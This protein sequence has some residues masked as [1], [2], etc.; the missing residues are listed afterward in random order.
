[1]R[2]REETVNRKV[3]QHKKRREGDDRAE[4]EEIGKR[5][6]LVNH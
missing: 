2:F 5:K 6:R 1:M 3:L 4:E